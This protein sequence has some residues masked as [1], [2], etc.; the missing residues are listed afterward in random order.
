M[1]GAHITLKDEKEETDDKFKYAILDTWGEIKHQTWHGDVT[2]LAFCV[3]QQACFAVCRL[4]ANAEIWKKMSYRGVKA[5]L[6]ANVS[7]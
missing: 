4:L 1:F 2:F 7:R 3:R 5:F 6:R